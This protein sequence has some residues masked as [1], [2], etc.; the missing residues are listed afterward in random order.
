MLVEPV[1]EP[2]AVELVEDDVGSPEDEPTVPWDVPVE[3]AL[4]VP[5][6][7][8]PPAVL[9]DVVPP[10]GTGV[11]VLLAELELS[12]PVPSVV[13][14]PGVAAS[15]VVGAAGSAALTAPPPVL[16]IAGASPGTV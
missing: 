13:G 2:A 9:V 7:G 6:V 14:V 1:V 15:P 11:P 16:G 3:V 5:A 8:M 10:L 4:V 12:E